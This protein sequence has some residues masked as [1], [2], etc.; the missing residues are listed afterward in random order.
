[1]KPTPAH[2][3]A[4]PARR[5]FLIRTRALGGL[6]A[7]SF[8]DRLGLAGAFAQAA[9]AAD[10]KALVCVFLFGGNDSNHMVVPCEPEEYARYAAARGPQGQGGLAL[11]LATLLRISP[12]SLG[13][14]FGLHPNLPGLRDLFASG[15][16]AILANV[17]TLVV[18]LTKQQ[19]LARAAAIPDSLFSHSDQQQ[20]WQTAGLDSSTLVTGWGG[21]LAQTVAPLNG[22]SSTPF[23]LSLAGSP[24]FAAGA[25][26]A[27]SLPSAGSYGLAGF[28]SSASSQARLNADTHRSATAAGC[29]THRST[30]GAGSSA[31]GL[32]CLDGWL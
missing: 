28:G 10:Y 27:L 1:M 9:G 19:Y 4:D 6:A 7:A 8:L 32:L 20:Q 18:P 25:R 13:Q 17:G 21:R 31:P 12:L 2:V 22:A 11:D 30:R 26:D 24:Q 14:S 29:E 3:P 5:R 23:V 16:A 15:K